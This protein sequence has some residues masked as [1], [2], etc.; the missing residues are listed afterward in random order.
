MRSRKCLICK[1]IFV[2]CRSTNRLCALE[3]CKIAHN[4]KLCRIA[5]LR[6]RKVAWPQT[7][8]CAQCKAPFAAMRAAHKYCNWECYYAHQM[9]YQRERLQQ[10]RGE[11]YSASRPCIG[12]GKI[13]H[14]HGS[15]WRKVACDRRCR[16]RA[17]AAC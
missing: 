17:R 2:P 5:Y 10:Q 15:A 8:P 7:R 9:V 14:V 12:C 16:Y 11:P 4:K 3:E 6:R 13:M 1:Q